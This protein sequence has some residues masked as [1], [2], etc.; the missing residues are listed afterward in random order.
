MELKKAFSFGVPNHMVMQSLGT[1]WILRFIIVAYQII[2]NS[3]FPKQRFTSD[4]E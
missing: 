2:K 1:Q 4:A 3:K